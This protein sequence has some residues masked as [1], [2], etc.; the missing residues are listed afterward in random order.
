MPSRKSSTKKQPAARS[1]AAK[2]STAKKT[3]ARAE[4]TLPTPAIDTGA[5]FPNKALSTDSDPGT[6][7]D[8]VSTIRRNERG[9]AMTVHVAPRQRADAGTSGTSGG[10]NRSSS[11]RRGSVTR[12]RPSTAPT[13]VP[14]T[15]AADAVSSGAASTE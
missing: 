7:P 13:S 6:A 5:P 12:A 11:P 1:S 10:A 15:S 14:S 3:G 8:P 2:T 9:P 4:R